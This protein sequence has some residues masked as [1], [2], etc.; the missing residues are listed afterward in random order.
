MEIEPTAL[1][2]F[3]LCCNSFLTQQ[4]QWAPQN[5]IHHINSYLQPYNSFDHM[6]TGGRKA[7]TLF[8]AFRVVPDLTPTPV[9]SLKQLSQN[10]PTNIPPEAGW[11]QHQPRE[12]S[13]TQAV[14]RGACTKLV[15]KLNLYTL[16]FLHT[17]NKHNI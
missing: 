17:I 16:N 5:I 11:K 12:T 8:V 6:H 2:S 3:E 7:K 10:E 9:Q 13:T 1:L 4:P 14:L 15:G